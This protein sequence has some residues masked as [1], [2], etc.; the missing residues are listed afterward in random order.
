MMLSVSAPCTMKNSPRK[1]PDVA[2]E[3]FRDRLT[4]CSPA[5]ITNNPLKSASVPGFC[6]WA[7]GVM[8]PAM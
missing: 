7:E 3:P 8:R 2:D 6:I 5:W 4:Q 1:R